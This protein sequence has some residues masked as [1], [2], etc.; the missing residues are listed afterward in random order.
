[1]GSSGI[2]AEP[3]AVFLPLFR[4]GFTIRRCLSREPNDAKKQL[5]MS[6]RKSDPGRQNSRFKG[7][8]VEMCLAYSRS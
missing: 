5:Y 6:L 4:E 7:L 1:M 8:E 3:C 2:V